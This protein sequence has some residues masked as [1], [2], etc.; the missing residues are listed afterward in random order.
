[1][2]DYKER[3]R[4]EFWTTI[5]VV[6]GSVVICLVSWGCYRIGFE[7][8]LFLGFIL[9]YSIFFAAC[10]YLGVVV[11]ICS[12]LSILSMILDILKFFVGG[13]KKDR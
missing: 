12:F 3:M 9:S 4:S 8:L 11:V 2:P 10:V 13:D 6:F 7:N 1:M 5:S